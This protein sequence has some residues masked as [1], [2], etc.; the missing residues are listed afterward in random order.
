[1]TSLILGLN[2]NAQSQVD[3]K[4]IDSLGQQFTA[5]LKR[6]ELDQFKNGNP[7][8]NTWTYAKLLKYKEDLNDP[9]TNIRFGDFVEPSTDESIYGYNLFAYKRPDGG[10]NFDYYF[11]AIISVDISGKE[12][13]IENAYLF[14]EQEGLESWWRHVFGLYYKDT[15]KDIPEAYRFP[16]CPPP[17]FKS[18]N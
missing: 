8:K 9:D 6:G 15:I 10:D 12:P 18:D 16:T 13:K 5:K 4:A 17:P 14:T 7:P 2:I 11:V 1:M 3:F